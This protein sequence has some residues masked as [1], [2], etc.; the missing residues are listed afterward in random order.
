MEMPEEFEGKR[1]AEIWRRVMKT[2]QVS[3]PWPG[4]ESA[5][6][7]ARQT[8]RL[9]AAVRALADEEMAREELDQARRT[10]D[11]NGVRVYATVVRDMRSQAAKLLG[12]L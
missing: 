5:A 11:V 12:D 1:E 7:E 8:E 2:R 6:D 4:A 9:A 3:A 10:A